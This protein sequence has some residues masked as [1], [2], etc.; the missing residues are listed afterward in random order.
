VLIDGV[1]DGKPRKLVSTAS[2]NGY[3]FTLDRVTGQPV[4]SAKFGTT[5][6]WA[7]G[8]RANGAPDPDAPPARGRS[9]R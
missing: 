2:R 8:M 1:I 4:V 6:N 5:V 7:K 3:F 9:P